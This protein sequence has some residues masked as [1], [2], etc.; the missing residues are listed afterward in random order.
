MTL[1]DG[2]IVGADAVIVAAGPW[3][4]RLVPGLAQRVTPSR[5]IVAY[6]EPPP[7][8]AEA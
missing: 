2:S 1:T 4:A 3:I 8:R 7:G 6:V 5:Q